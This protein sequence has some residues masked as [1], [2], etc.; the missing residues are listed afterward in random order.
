MQV[1]FIITC[2]NK[3]HYWPHLF[4]ILSEYKTIKPIISL[5]YN[6]N[7]PEFPC[8]VR[9]PNMG[10]QLGEYTLIKAGYESLKNQSTKWVKLS[11]DSWLLKESIILDIF[12]KMEKAKL[13]YSGNYWNIQSQ[14]STDVFFADTTHG[15]IF[16]NFVLDENDAKVINEGG[17]VLENFLAR[18][19]AKTGTAYIINEREPV[20]PNN[21]HECQ[22]LGWTMHDDLET[23]LKRAEDWSKEF[24]YKSYLEEVKRGNVL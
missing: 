18:A 16:E 6:G 13:V 2:F 19:V 11:I 5:V 23:N 1:N 8:D 21:R 22:R 24:D 7:D 14:L 17:A 20:H 12:D 10:H 9:L 4:K 15:N 3:E